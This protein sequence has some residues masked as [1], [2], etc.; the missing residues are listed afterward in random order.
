MMAVYEGAY[1][2]LP[3]E[4]ISAAE[5]RRR[6]DAILP[7]DWSAFRSR[8]LEKMFCDGDACAI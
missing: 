4:P 7:F 1:A 2:Q 6:K 3:E 5:Y 8:G